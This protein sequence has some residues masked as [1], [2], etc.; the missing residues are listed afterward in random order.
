MDIS[1][2]EG[3]HYCSHEVQEWVG[4]NDTQWHL[5]LPHNSIA[6]GATNELLQHL[7]QETHSFSSEHIPG[8][9]VPVLTP[10]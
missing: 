7:R 4:E 1:S 8:A 10:S 2:D 6:A 9:V 3:I 5:P